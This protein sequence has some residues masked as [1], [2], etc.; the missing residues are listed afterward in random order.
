MNN[1]Q[2]VVAIVRGRRPPIPEEWK[3]DPSKEELVKIMRS[4][5][6]QTPSDRPDVE[7]VLINLGGTPIAVEFGI[8]YSTIELPLA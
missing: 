3:T 5:W 7:R 1:Y 6:E 8:R 2:A 4:C